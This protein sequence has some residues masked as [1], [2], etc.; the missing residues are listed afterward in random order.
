M[1][2][3][4]R[5]VLLM[6][7]LLIVIGIIWDTFR[8]K[9]K[10]AVRFD[11]SL[12]HKKSY[13]LSFFSFLNKNFYKKKKREWAMANDALL[14]DSDPALS[15]DLI[16]GLQRDFSELPNS[17]FEEVRVIKPKSYA[18]NKPANALGSTLGDTL[19]NTAL[20]TSMTRAQTQSPNHNSGINSPYKDELIVLNVV[21]RQPGV[22]SGKKL[23]EAFHYLHFY[24][25]EMQIFHRYENIDGTGKVIF[26]I[27]SMVEPGI[28]E[29]SKMEQFSTPGLTLFFTV[30]RAN[31]SIAAFELMLRTAKQ[32]ANRL[33]GELR[34]DKQRILT[35]KGI[36]Q[37][38]NRVRSFA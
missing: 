26:S 11:R 38:R 31:Q 32:L 7:G 18:S 36:D 2:T 1:N 20:A 17:S 13:L 3:S 33:D 23:Y 10:E 4:I 24:F 6:V 19:G 35:L 27:A 12:Y 34:D 37:Y 14:E 29:I 16:L 28:F 25:G 8:G 21:A 5:I 30:E 15:D 9:K 22:F